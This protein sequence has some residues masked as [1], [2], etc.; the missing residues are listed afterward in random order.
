MKRIMA[1]FLLLL[2]VVCWAQSRLI[3]DFVQEGKATQEMRSGGMNAAHHS[4]PIGS[5][6]MVKNNANGKE[7]EVTIIGRIPAS[8]DRVID[9]TRDAARAIE[10]GSEGTI[11]LYFYRP[12]AA[13][14]APLVTESVLPAPKPE[15]VAVLPAE[16]KPVPPEPPATSPPVSEPPKPVTVAAP[17][18]PKKPIQITIHN[19]IPPANTP[20]EREP[21]APPPVRPLAPPPAAPVAQPP[22]PPPAAPIVQQPSPVSTVRVM[23]GLPDPN[24]GKYFNLQVGA[25]SSP[26]GAAQAL[27][28]V[29]NAGF[30]AIQEQSGSFYRVLAVSVLA[31]D[32]YFASQ[33]LGVFGFSE[34]WIRE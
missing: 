11:T 33:R 34:I 8:Q 1:T 21:P 30:D 12:P 26:S 31:R 13:E 7:I 10:I 19:H 5:R 28:Q 9:I 4:L 17:P 18:E 14:A 32:V 29:Q 27:R 23:P 15:V 2:T 24:S 6:P 22:I 3:D 16:P 25:F 20:A